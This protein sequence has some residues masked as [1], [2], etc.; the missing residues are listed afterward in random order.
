MKKGK[1]IVLE[2]GEGSGKSSAISYLKDKLPAANF[3]FTREPG[4]TENAEEIRRVILKKRPEPLNTLSQLLLFE[5]AR[6]E[7]VAKKILPA[8]E[9]GLNVICDR[10]SASTYAYQI[11]AGDGVAYKD[12]FFEADALARTGAT[13]DHTIFL[14]VDPAVGIARKTSSGEYLNVFDEQDI[15]FHEQVRLGMKGYLTGEPHTVV[16]AGKP[17]QEV[18][19][20]VKRV[21]L[22]LVNH[23]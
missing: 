9:R 7:H 3:L 2:G 18:R 13:P 12:F 6:R 11:V 20:E 10:F 17:Q 4:G 8:L 19:E 5:A 21:I 22:E 15:V 14:D 16:D 23:A 1:F